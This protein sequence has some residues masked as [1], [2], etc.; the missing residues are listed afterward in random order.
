[1]GVTGYTHNLTKFFRLYVLNHL[2]NELSTT[3]RNTKSTNITTNLFRS[4]AQGRSILENTQG[5]FIA[6]RNLFRIKVGVSI[7]TQIFFQHLQ[8]HRIV[9]PQN[10]KLNQTVIDAVIIVVGSNSITSIIVSRTVNR[11]DVVNIHITRHNHDTAGMLASC[12][13]NPCQTFN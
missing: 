6:N 9:V 12:T 2:T 13:L 4:Y 8:Y 10:I 11:C 1:M 3:F 7:F 5:F